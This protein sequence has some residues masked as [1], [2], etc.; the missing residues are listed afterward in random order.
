MTEGSGYEAECP[1]CSYETLVFT[2]TD[3]P[4]CPYCRERKDPFLPPSDSVS[5]ILVDPT[6]ID[7]DTIDGAY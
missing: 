2:T 7:Q 4:S 3:L 1:N 5:L 6:V